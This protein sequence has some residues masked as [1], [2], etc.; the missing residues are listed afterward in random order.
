MFAFESAVRSLQ[1]VRRENGKVTSSPP[2]SNLNLASVQND[3]K[4]SFDTAFTLLH[5]LPTVSRS[6][7]AA[8]RSAVSQK[9]YLN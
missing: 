3:V 1:L 7:I 4:L 8:E 6:A 5:A 2:Y 9:S